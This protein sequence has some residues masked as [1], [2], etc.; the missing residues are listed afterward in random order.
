MI[1]K[2]KKIILVVNGYGCH[3]DTPLGWVYLPK[4]LRFI[5]EHYTEIFLVVFCGGETQKKTAPGISEAQLMYNW[6]ITR[7]QRDRKCSEEEI[8]EQ[9]QFAIEHE[10]YTSFENSRLAAKD[11]INPA[12]L[13]HEAVPSDVYIVHFCEALRAPTVIM[14]DRHFM[15]QFVESIDDIMV[16]TASW[17]R[18]DPFKMTIW[19]GKFPGGFFAN[20]LALKFPWLGLAEWE[21]RRRRRRSEQI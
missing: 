21:G 9:I 17:E 8:L 14:L 7:L 19:N 10:S 5:E 16:E 13:F 6:I 3:L 18:T 15:L 4:V 2:L 11:Y 20:W 1:A 12:M